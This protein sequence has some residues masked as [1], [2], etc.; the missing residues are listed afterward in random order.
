MGFEFLSDGW[1]D[2]AERIRA[3][4]NPEVPDAVK[5]LVINLK[6]TDAP[7]G[8]IEARMAGGKFE[9]GLDA[10]VLFALGRVCQ[11]ALNHFVKV[12]AIRRLLEPKWEPEEQLRWARAAD[13]ITDL[14]IIGEEAKPRYD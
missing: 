9:K 1:F 8:D 2:E 14:L 7:G 13:F 5:D 6:V 11:H 10:D 4:I 3:E 12:M